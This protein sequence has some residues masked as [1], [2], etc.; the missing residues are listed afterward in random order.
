MEKQT[1]HVMAIMMKALSNESRLGI[2]NAL[3]EK[4][5][6]WTELINEMQINPKSLR[7][8]LRF[9]SRSGLIR[10]RKPV[11]FELTEAG[12]A[13]IELSIKDIMTTMKKVAQLA[14]PYLT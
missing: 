2:I 8:H 14:K 3:Y 11:G 6:T 12:Q 10:K 4:P 9:L 5:K 13:F 1:I 7:D